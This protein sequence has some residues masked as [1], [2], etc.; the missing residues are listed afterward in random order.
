MSKTNPR[1]YI[2]PITGRLIKSNGK[3]YKNLKKFFF[4]LKKLH[5]DPQR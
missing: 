2:N 3:I 4:L 1:F 5:I